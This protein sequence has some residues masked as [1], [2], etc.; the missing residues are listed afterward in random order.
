VEGNG[1]QK[2]FIILG[3]VC[4]LASII[5]G[6]LRVGPVELPK[7]ESKFVRFVV[8]A[9]GVGLILAATKIHK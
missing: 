3:V 5:G 2:I 6:G 1:M 8:A 9:F 7:I 4:I